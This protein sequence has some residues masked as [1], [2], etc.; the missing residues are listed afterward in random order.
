MS[1]DLV[2]L[3][4]Q[5]RSIEKV[6]VDFRGLYNTASNALANKGI[7]P[8]G[9]MGGAAVGTV[10]G[11]MKGYNTADEDNKLKGALAGGLTGGL[12]GALLG[13]TIH[14][15]A[16]NLKGIGSELKSAKQGYADAYKSKHEM[17]FLERLK[18][19]FSAEGRQKL[20]QANQRFEADKTAKDALR[21]SHADKLSS[22]KVKIQM[23]PNLSYDQQVNKINDLY[24]SNAQGRYEMASDKIKGAVFGPLA[25]ALTASAISGAGASAFAPNDPSMTIDSIKTKKNLSEQDRFIINEKLKQIQASRP[26]QAQPMGQPQGMSNAL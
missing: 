4:R 24:S 14:Q 13:H 8:L 5:K 1:N 12:G 22:E 19:R 18:N 16:K 21:K 3:I 7:N 23:D 26:Q 6:A 9:A 20:Q 25:G 17:G 2:A 15:S 11:A 10:T